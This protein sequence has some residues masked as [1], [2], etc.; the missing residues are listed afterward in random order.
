MDSRLLKAAATILA[1]SITHLLNI[2]IKFGVIPTD[3]KCARVIP[4]TD[5]GN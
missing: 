5:M 2:S 4:V 1:P 3:W